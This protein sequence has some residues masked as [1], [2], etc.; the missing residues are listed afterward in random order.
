MQSLIDQQ[1]NK[2]TAINKQIAIDLLP[3]GQG[4]MSNIARLVIGTHFNNF[5]FNA[6]GTKFFGELAQIFGVQ[7]GIHMVGIVQTIALQYSKFVGL[8]RL[9]FGAV[10]TKFAA[11][12]LL[13]APQ[14]K[15]LESGGPAIF[16]GKTKGVNIGLANIFPV[17]KLDTQFKGALHLGHK[18]PFINTQ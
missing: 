1:A 11:D 8:G 18:L 14:P 16:S 2:A 6:L 9:Q 3:R 5:A 17:G 7:A 13:F 12:T 4:D 15:V 10:I